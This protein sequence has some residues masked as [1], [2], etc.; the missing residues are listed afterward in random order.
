[1]YVVGGIFWD[2]D[3]HMGFEVNP[4]FRVRVF[5]YSEGGGRMFDE[6]VGESH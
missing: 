6:D 2:H 3:V 4:Y 5:V 1:M